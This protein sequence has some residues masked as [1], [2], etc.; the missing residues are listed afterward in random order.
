MNTPIITSLRVGDDSANADD[1]P[2]L[3]WEAP[4][5]ELLGLL[6]IIDKSQPAP[7]VDGQRLC[8]QPSHDLSEISRIFLSVTISSAQYD[9][10][11]KTIHILD[12]D[13]V[14]PAVNK[15]QEFANHVLQRTRVSILDNLYSNQVIRSTIATSSSRTVYAIVAS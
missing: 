15:L 3:P 13:A 6:Q 5:L 11:L 14:P 12:S 8:F 1:P 4:F 2:T 9:I 7:N 10:D